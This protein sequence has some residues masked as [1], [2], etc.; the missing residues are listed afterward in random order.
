VVAIEMIV[1]LGDYWPSSV[2]TERALRHILNSSKEAQV[3][4]IKQS[5]MQHHVAT[6]HLRLRGALPTESEKMNNL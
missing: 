3:N 1:A 4:F 6:E 2:L 5:I